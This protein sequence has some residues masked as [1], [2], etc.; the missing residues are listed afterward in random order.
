MAINNAICLADAVI[1]QTRL[2]ALRCSGIEERRMQHETKWRNC[3]ELHSQFFRN[4][5]H[6]EFFDGTEARLRVGIPLRITLLNSTTS[7]TMVRG[8][9]ETD[10]VYN[11]TYKR[12][13]PTS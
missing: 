3:P 2:A 12:R 5:A 6:F 4:R 11:S 13:R 8:E 7:S 10:H 1:S 9:W